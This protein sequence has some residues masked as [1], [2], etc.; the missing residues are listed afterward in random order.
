MGHIAWQHDVNFV[1]PDHA[2]LTTDGL[3]F[4]TDVEGAE[5]LGQLAVFS[6][7]PSTSFLLLVGSDVL[8]HKWHGVESYPARRMLSRTLALTSSFR[9][10]ITNALCGSMPRRTV[11]VA[12]MPATVPDTGQTTGSRNWF[13]SNMSISGSNG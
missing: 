10:N 8:I 7:F 3:H 4:L 13:L 1:M 12:S 2:V 11:M 9:S 5:Q 6:L